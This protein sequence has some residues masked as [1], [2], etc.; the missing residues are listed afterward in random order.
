MQQPHFFDDDDTLPIQPVRD[1]PRAIVYVYET[2]VS[3]IE[4]GI[5]ADVSGVA[6]PYRSEIL[7]DFV[8]EL[9]QSGFTVVD[10]RPR[11]VL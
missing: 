11:E 2:I 6:E 9:Q 8:V 1:E 7:N 5:L 10:R 4:G 3:D